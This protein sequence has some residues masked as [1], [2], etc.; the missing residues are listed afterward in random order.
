MRTVDRVVVE[1][2]S[3]VVISEVTYN[4][5]LFCFIE[6]L[7]LFADVRTIGGG[8][9]NGTVG[10]CTILAPIADR[11]I[12]RWDSGKTVKFSELK[13]IITRAY[14]AAASKVSYTL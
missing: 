7:V 14:R 2:F 3:R 11:A 5:M 10:R 8:I 4:M 12:S 13:F 9:V 1:S 6:W